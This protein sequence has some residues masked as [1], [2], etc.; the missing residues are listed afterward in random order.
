[1]NGNP[2]QLDPGQ[3]FVGGHLKVD[4]QPPDGILPPRHVLI[5][6]IHDGALNK[7]LGIIY[8]P[9]NGLCGVVSQ[10]FFKMG[11]T[12]TPTLFLGLTFVIANNDNIKDDRSKK[13][14]GWA[15]EI[16]HNT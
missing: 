9:I 13:E 12:I 3:S 10:D 1:M 11:W 6:D 2:L 16:K 15:G 5:R 14:K 4:R 7:C 8:I